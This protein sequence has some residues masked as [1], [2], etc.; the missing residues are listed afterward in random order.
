LKT[1]WLFMSSGSLTCGSRH[2]RIDGN[3]SGRRALVAAF[4]KALSDERVG[5][6][7]G[8]GAS[9]L[10]AF[11]S[12]GRAESSELEELEAPPHRNLAA[13][14][15]AARAVPAGDRHQHRRRRCNPGFDCTQACLGQQNIRSTAE[16]RK[17][18]LMMGLGDLHELSF[19]R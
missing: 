9:T 1:R 2:P 8:P 11:S 7:W 10:F 5:S 16:S 15:L 18:R 17:K 12:R 19:C 3:S 4:T 6:S 14:R 13:R